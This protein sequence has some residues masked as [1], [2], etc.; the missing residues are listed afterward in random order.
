MNDYS[1][2]KSQIIENYN[3]QDILSYVPHSI[4][5]TTE[6]INEIFKECNCTVI[7][8]PKNLHQRSIITF[9][10]N[11][12]PEHI[13]VAHLNEFCN[14]PNKNYYKSSSKL[15]NSN[16]DKVKKPLK[17][18][19]EKENDLR[20]SMKAEQCELISEYIKG[21][22]PVYYLFEGF[23]YKTTPTRWKSGHRAHK[24]KC[25]RY[26]QNYIKQLFANEGC[27]LISEYK[28]QKS[29]LKY[30]YNDQIYEV[31]FNDWKFYNSR[32]HLGQNHTFFT[33]NPEQK[34]DQKIDA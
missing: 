17:T 23:E 22:K 18:T 4:N 6:I 31:I 9:Y 24:C 13:I 7:K 14:N 8:S 27:E 15:Y 21:D 3:S 11:D 26:T 25:I 28:N 29:R 2:I 10:R 19:A 32:P 30:K 34:P 16:N 12:N 33:E 20:E 5:L 1:T